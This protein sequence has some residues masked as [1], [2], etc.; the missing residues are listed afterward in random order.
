M[1]LL[2]QDQF[3]FVICFFSRKAQ[4]SQDFISLII[5]LFAIVSLALGTIANPGVYEEF[6]KNINRNDLT[7]IK[8][9]ASGWIA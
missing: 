4:P 1:H 8:L 7:L 2:Y 9:G 6:G 3:S 5:S